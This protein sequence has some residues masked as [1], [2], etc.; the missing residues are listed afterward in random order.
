M[1]RVKIAALSRRR[2]PDDEVQLKLRLPE[3]LRQRVERLAERNARSMNSEILQI[4]ER[5]TD[6]LEAPPAYEPLSQA[7][8]VQEAILDELRRMNAKLREP[9]PA[10][11]SSIIGSKEGDAK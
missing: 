7:R 4:L 10:V 11:G 3:W 6:V 5:A 2:R 9:V 1:A 8:S